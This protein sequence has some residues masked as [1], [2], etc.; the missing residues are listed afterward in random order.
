MFLYQRAKLGWDI[1]KTTYHNVFSIVM[2]LIGTLLMIG[3]LSKLFKIPDIILT[4]ISTVLTIISRSIYRFATTT[5][6]FF[7]GTGVDFCFSVKFLG[8]R[9]IISKLVPSEDL[10]TMF[11]IM[12]LF[13]ALA[14]LVF[15]YIY[16]TIYQYLIEN[17]NRD[18][19][20]IFSLSIA[21]LLISFIVYS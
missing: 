11:A 13:E 17:K 12:G 1:S 15:S 21:L 3:L 6:E 7:V 2:G 9:S 20:E 14:A 19:S 16:P 10:S 5:V 18:I 4:M 8:V